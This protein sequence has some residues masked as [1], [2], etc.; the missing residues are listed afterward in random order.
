[1]RRTWGI[2]LLLVAAAFLGL[3]ADA[4]ASTTYAYA[5]I[6]GGTDGS[7]THGAANISDNDSAFFGCQ[8]YACAICPFTNCASFASTTSTVI[9]HFGYGSS[10]VSTQPNVKNNAEGA[11]Y[12]GHQFTNRGTAVFGAINLGLVGQSLKAAALLNLQNIRLS[13]P[14]TGLQSDYESTTFSLTL[15]QQPQYG[16]SMKLYGDGY[17]DAV[18][19]FAGNVSVQ[20]EEEYWVAQYTGPAS[21]GFEMPVGT[22]FSMELNTKVETPDYLSAGGGGGGGG[23]AYNEPL[24]EITIPEGYQFTP[25]P[26]TLGLVAFGLLAA[27]GRKRR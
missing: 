15:D 17:C 10:I 26:A 12:N 9:V 13:L 3:S 4:H 18:G 14:K 19:A 5:A 11:P 24:Y 6:N 27:L 21:L 7:S 1:M 2:G 22:P 23:G 25:E 8:S 16:G 20:E